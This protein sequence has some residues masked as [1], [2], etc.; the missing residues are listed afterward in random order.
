MRLHCP[1]LLLHLFVPSLGSIHTVCLKLNF[2]I[3]TLTHSTTPTPAHSHTQS[4]T[5]STTHTPS[6]HPHTHILNHSHTHTL[7]HSHTQWSPTHSHTQPLTYP[8]T[9]THTQP[10]THPHSQVI[11]ENFTPNLPGI[12]V[13]L[14]WARLTDWSLT[15]FMRKNTASGNF[16]R[17]HASRLSSQVDLA[18]SQ[19]WAIFADCSA[20]VHVE[21][22]N[23]RWSG[24]WGEGKGEG[25]RGREKGKE[26]WE[27][28]KGKRR[29]EE[30]GEGEALSGTIISLWGITDLHKSWYS[31][32]KIGARTQR[33]HHTFQSQAPTQISF[34]S[35]YNL[36]QEPENKAL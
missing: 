7:N 21:L 3:N 2:F 15:S 9:H 23:L 28:R 22:W 16:L 13:R 27:D 8:H 17:S 24:W 19:R 14:L 6:G 1:H 31:V 33:E 26:R 5:H 30:Q 34:P 11:E 35:Q 4:L 29:R 10:L 12:L 25:K 18:S 32:I 36:V 20:I